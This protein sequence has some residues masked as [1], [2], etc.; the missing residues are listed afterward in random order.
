MILGR[1]RTQKPLEQGRHRSDVLAH[2]GE[3]WEG[4]IIFDDPPIHIAGHGV[5]TATVFVALDLSLEFLMF[6]LELES[7]FLELLVPGLQ[8]LYPYVMWGPC[9]PLNLIVE[10][11]HWGSLSLMDAFNVSL[12]GACLETFMRGMMAPPTRVRAGG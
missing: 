2:S 7:C 5:H 3:V 1:R 6:L 9:I 4:F 8:L 11:I 12:R 10:A